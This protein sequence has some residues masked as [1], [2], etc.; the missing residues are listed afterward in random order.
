MVEFEEESSRSSEIAEQVTKISEP[1]RTSRGQLAIKEEE[2]H[3]DGYDEKP[4][5]SYT[6]TSTLFSPVLRSF[7]LPIS[8]V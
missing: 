6:H 2:G 1:L 3:E 4:R 8:L 7:S 5:E